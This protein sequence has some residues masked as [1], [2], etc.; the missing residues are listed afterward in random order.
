M[1]LFVVALVLA[2]AECW[3]AQEGKLGTERR[4]SADLSK[5]ATLDI[6][7]RRLYTERDGERGRDGG[8]EEKSIEQP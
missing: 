8:S 5:L 7:Y 1:C 2:Q 4:K 6:I 3:N